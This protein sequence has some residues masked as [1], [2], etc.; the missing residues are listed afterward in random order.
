T[1][2]A[3]ERQHPAHERVEAGPEQLL[4]AVAVA[5]G[6]DANDAGAVAE[7][8]LV[9]SVVGG[10]AVVLDAAREEVD[11]TNVLA[12]GQGAREFHD[13]LGLAAGVRVASELE[14]RAA[15][16]TV[17]ADHRDV[18]PSFAFGWHRHHPLGT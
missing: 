9:A 2:V 11:L 12:P 8:F 6:A 18:H 13:V 17:H 15:D 4:T 5:T 1:F 14:L 16:Q 10:D 3:V 7:R